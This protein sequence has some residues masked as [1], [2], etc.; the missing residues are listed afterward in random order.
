MCHFGADLQLL[1]IGMTFA[2]AHFTEI[3]S[4]EFSFFAA[5]VNYEHDFNREI[6]T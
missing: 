4:T 2:F 6:D 3:Y 1:T 5:W